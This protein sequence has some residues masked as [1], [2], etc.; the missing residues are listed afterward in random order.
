LPYPAFAIDTVGKVIAWNQACE[1][2]LGVKAEEILG[3]GDYE[4]ALPFYGERRPILIDLVFASPEEIEQN[5]TNVRREGETLV[6]EAMV[7]PQGRERYFIGTAAPL[8]D[9][10]GNIAGAIETFRDITEQKQSEAA[11]QEFEQR[12]ADIIDFLPTPTFV[13][14]LEGN[15]IAWNQALVEVTGVKAEDILGKGNYEYA[16][17]F[18]GKR[19][20]LLIDLIFEPEEEVA[21]KYTNVRREGNSLVAE[22][23]V[24]PRGIERHYLLSAAPLY[25]AQGN[26][27]GAIENFRDITEQKRAEEELR[28]Y[29]DQLEELVEARTAELEDRVRELNALQRLMSREGWQEF[30]AVRSQA[31]PG[32]LFD[33]AIVR[34]AERDELGLS[35]NGRS[36][37]RASEAPAADKS[38]RSSAV[39]KPLAVSGESIGTLGI[40]DDPDNPLSPEDQAFL[41]EI[42]SQ[43]AEAL[44][45]ARL[46][47]QSRASLAETEAQAERLAALSALGQELAQTTSI[48]D[49]LNLVATEIESI[50]GS[51]LGG[52]GLFDE[53]TQQLEMYAL[54][55]PQGALLEGLQVSIKGSLLGQVFQNQ[56]L[57]TIPD[58]QV[59][60]EI[61]VRDWLE[62]GMRSATVAPLVA[63]GRVIGTVHVA[64]QK[65]NAY[66]EQDG[67]LM[68]QVASLLASSLE[69]RRLF[70][71]TR[72]ALAE[73]EATQRRYTVQAWETY[74]RRKVAASHEQDREGV[75]PLGDELPPEVSQ[76][77]AQKKALAISAIPALSAG[78]DGGQTPSAGA[79]SSLLVP[80]T[81]RDEVIGVLGLQE[82]AEARQWTPEEIALVEGIAEQVALA[83]EQIRLFDETQ[84]RAA[85]E[86]RLGEIGDK[87]RAAQSLEEALQVAI[88]EVGLSL[89]A[90]QTTVQLEVE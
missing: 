38:T 86:K 48:A 10:Q 2:A 42:A 44:E 31:A 56:Q 68:L 17:P 79:K 69:S 19:R 90:P 30:Q 40:Y 71:E 72:Q 43:V 41:D 87:I 77:V 88:K 59:R 26:L 85:R 20:P 46:L 24:F 22:N 27:V 34:P 15:V 25:D 65:L 9:A 49:A 64:S 3:Q 57:L 32:Y 28:Q 47:E 33:Q 8:Y 81:V 4:Y 36:E 82:T 78:A 35:P 21:K 60:D 73:V 6:A 12:L 76:A 13:I 52:L 18:F 58:L 45:R 55:G 37:E 5:Y 29:Q 23:R 74:R 66:T 1:T 7:Y 63:S 53:A 51:D 84:Q 16:L 62:Q 50:I 89:K 83:A 54:A 11:R 67:R 70:E 75:P 39:T 14:D 80:L 61:D